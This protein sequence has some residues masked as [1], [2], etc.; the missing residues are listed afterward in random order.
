MMVLNI[1]KSFWERGDFPQ[2]F[3]NGS[4]LIAL[5]NP[6]TNGTQ[7]AP[8]D[9]RTFSFSFLATLDGQKLIRRWYSL[10]SDPQPRCRWNER[11]VPG[12]LR[13][14]TLVGWFA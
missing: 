8:F 2:V 13:R 4:E 14:E 3:N 6:W 9:K 7:A 11:V 10:L 1:N 12:W 5:K